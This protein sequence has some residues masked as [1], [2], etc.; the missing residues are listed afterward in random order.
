MP[1]CNRV[2]LLPGENIDSYGVV[3]VVFWGILS[4][5]EDKEGMY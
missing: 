2:I 4:D 3:M 5:L 1:G